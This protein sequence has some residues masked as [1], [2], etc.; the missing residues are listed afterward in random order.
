MK[1]DFSDQ[2]KS[3]AIELGFE[4]IGITKAEPISKEKEYLES[5]IN[6]K[7]HALSMLRKF[8]DALECHDKALAIDDKNEKIYVNKALALGGLGKF[9]ESLKNSEH[10]ISI[11]QNYAMAWNNAAYA[12]HKLGRHEDALEYVEKALELDPADTDTLDS[13]RAILESLGRTS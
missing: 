2:I 9:E 11:N 1:K 3:R 6:N 10:A 8:E 5:W 12:L 4:K 13:K 7:G